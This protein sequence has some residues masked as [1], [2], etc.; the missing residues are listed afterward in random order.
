VILDPAERKKIVLAAREKLCAECT[1]AL[2]SYERPFR[3][4]GPGLVEWPVQCWHDRWKVSWTCRPRWLIF[5]M[6][7]TAA[8]LRRT[9]KDGALANRFRRRC[10]TRARYGGAA[11]VDG[12]ERVLRRAG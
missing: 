4:G 10:Y 7:R 8:I 11:I 5:S 3:R 9:T 12:N 2:K 6:R 1:V